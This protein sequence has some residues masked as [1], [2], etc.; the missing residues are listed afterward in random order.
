MTNEEKAKKA[1]NIELA[2]TS[3]TKEP[4]SDNQRLIAIVA[5]CIT[6]GLSDVKSFCESHGI[7]TSSILIARLTYFPEAVLEDVWQQ[8]TE[9]QKIEIQQDPSVLV[10]KCV[11]YLKAKNMDQSMIMGGR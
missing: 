1:Q 5:A 10:R 11:H 9:Q 4:L 6:D 3:T 7:D 2:V 8:S